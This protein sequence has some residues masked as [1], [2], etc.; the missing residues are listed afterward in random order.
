MKWRKRVV[1][2]LAIG[3][4][5]IFVIWRVLE[6]SSRYA[7]WW[8]L[9]VSE[10]FAVWALLP[11]PFLVA[12]ALL[13]RTRWVWI[14]LLIPTLWFGREYGGLFLPPAFATAHASVENANLRLM[15]FNT[16]YLYRS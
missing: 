14:A 11:L 5:S 7:A 4:A 12:A 1:L 2:I 6:A 13:W 16:L 9:R 15:T 8:P 3:Y 10:I